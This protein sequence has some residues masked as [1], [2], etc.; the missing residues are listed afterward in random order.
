MTAATATHPLG[1]DA[2]KPTQIP[3]PGWKEIAVRVY[4]EFS[5]DRVMLVAAGV[6]F[7]LLLAMV[8]AM[9]AFIS[10]YGLFAD[11]GTV[12]QHISFINDYMPSGGQE[13]VTD[14]LTRLSQQPSSGLGF[15][16][17]ISLAIALWSANA[18]MKALFEAMNVAYDETEK[19]SFVKLTL[20]SL[21]FTIGAIVLL[22]AIIGVVV[23]MPLIVETLGLGAMTELIVK[24]G[25]A[26]VLILAAL[27]ALSAL[28]RWGPSRSEAQWKWITPGAVVAVAIAMVGSL[29]FS[30]YVA[31]FGSYNETYGSLGA[32]IGFMTWLWIM[33]TFVITGGELNAEMEHQTREDTTTGPEQPLGTRGAEMADTVAQG[34]NDTGDDSKGAA[35]A[36]P[37]AKDASHGSGATSE[38]IGRQHSRDDS[39]SVP[40]DA[41]GRDPAAART[42]P[43][44]RREP[45]HHAA[46]APIRRPRSPG[47]AQEPIGV[48]GGLMLLGAV[49]L[50]VAA[51]KSGRN[52]GPGPAA[53]RNRE[54]PRHDLAYPGQPVEQPV[55]SMP[56]R[57]VAVHEQ[58]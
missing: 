7:Y 24:V 4:K 1:R 20:T 56:S 12:Q 43:A 37:S 32:I 9:T 15:A 29:L 54:A 48:V 2:A 19:R 18:G 53:R 47:E 17:V 30:W 27:L 51:G 49:A 55:A 42:N 31:N 26:V 16:L 46:G 44:L 21:A 58:H 36:A 6:T 28:Y 10:V 3:A 45:G 40:A 39:R 5:K 50:A 41:I 13:I 25:S 14:Q 38:S 23:V 8:P 11:P 57:R 35:H 33:N 52:A 22:L 34:P